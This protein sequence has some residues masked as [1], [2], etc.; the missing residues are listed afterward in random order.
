MWW[1]LSYSLV[2]YTCCVKDKHKYKS[3]L[4]LRGASTPL[5]FSPPLAKGLPA[6]LRTMA[7]GGLKGISNPS[8][9]PLPSPERLRAGRLYEREKRGLRIFRERR[10][11]L[12]G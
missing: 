8:L 12:R 9:S 4:S 10:G 3:A 2:A 7:G 6:V 1:L 5:S 11:G